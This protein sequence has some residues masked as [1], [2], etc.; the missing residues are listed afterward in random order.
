MPLL[1]ITFD[2]ENYSY[3]DEGARILS[4]LLYRTDVIR[5]KMWHYYLEL[6]Y[7]ILGKPEDKQQNNNNQGNNMFNQNQSQNKK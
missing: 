3:F 4:A 7:R 2:E 6:C 5:E 1:D